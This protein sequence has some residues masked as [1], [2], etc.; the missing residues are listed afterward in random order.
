MFEFRLYNFISINKTF[1]FLQVKSLFYNY[2]NLLLVIYYQDVYE[3]K[4]HSYVFG[5]YC[6]IVVL[7]WFSFNIFSENRKREFFF[8]NLK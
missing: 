8:T 1:F 4:M 5:D 2:Y 7:F 3:N 6:V